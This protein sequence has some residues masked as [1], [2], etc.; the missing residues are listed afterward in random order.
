MV[1][2]LPLTEERHA[3]GVAKT[4]CVHDSDPDEN[5]F[6]E[7]TRKRCR[8]ELFDCSVNSS[9]KASRYSLAMLLIW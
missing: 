4:R 6:Q 8:G 9:R 3:S 5:V 1:M 2:L 7:R